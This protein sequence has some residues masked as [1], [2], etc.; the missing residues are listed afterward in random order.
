MPIDKKIA[1]DQIDAVLKTYDDFSMNYHRSSS[2]S[3]EA[4]ERDHT[5][6]TWRMMDTLRRLAPRGSV[7]EVK[8]TNENE[9]AG[10]LKALRADYEADYIQT[11]REL[12]HGETF[13]DFLEMASHLVSERY[14]DAAAVIAGGVLEQH[15]RA[16]CTKH[17]VAPIPKNLNSLNEALY[18]QPPGAYGSQQM[19]QV[20]AWADIRNDAAHGHYDKVDAREVE[21]MI[22]GIRHFM[23]T[24]PA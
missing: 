10:V 3:D 24:H 13:S 16:L 7:Y 4:F 15:L 8:G 19:K 23:V 6:L 20:I 21:L 12:I 9:L 22:A 5:E 2:Y 1:L 14:K 11:I 17:G 18:R